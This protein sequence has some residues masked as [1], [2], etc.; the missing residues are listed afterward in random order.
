MRSAW[1]MKL[2]PGQE[3][4]YKRKHDE[5]WPELVTLLREAGVV[6]Y[7]IFL[8]EDTRAL[9]AVLTRRADHGLDALPNHPV[10]QRWWAMMADIMDTEADKSPVQVPSPVMRTD[11]I[12]PM[13]SAGRCEK[14]WKLDDETRAQLARKVAHDLISTIRSSS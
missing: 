13:V 1:V 3:A 9:F 4:E 5:I 10:M 12:G 6:E 14:D 2:K 7:R 11:L 8:D